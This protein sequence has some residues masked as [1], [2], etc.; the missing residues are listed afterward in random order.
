M[1]PV[2]IIPAR[3][4]ST[5]FPGKALAQETGTPLVVHVCERAAGAGAIGRVVVATDAEEIAGAVRAHGFEAVLTGEHENGTSRVAEA[6]RTLGLDPDTVIVNVQG[7]EPEIDPEII[8]AAAASLRARFGDDA[9]PR[10]GTVAGPFGRGEDPANPNIVK[11]IA[12]VVEPESG[13]APALYFTRA[14]APYPR[15]DAEPRYLKH[16]GI[17]A[18][19]LSD[20]LA[21]LALPP[22][23]LERT[24]KLEQLRWLEHG[25]PMAVAIRSAAHQGIDTPEQY[26]AFV[27]RWRSGSA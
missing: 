5:R 9:R 19:A 6:A 25:L 2:A 18:Y 8:E 26:A 10:C 24:E 27:A 21:Y 14:P 17:Y 7:D 12:G 13:V 15:D 23:P 3:L 4:G 16:V 11:A 1:K 22:S 20:L